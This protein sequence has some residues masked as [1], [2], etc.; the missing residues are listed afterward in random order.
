VAKAIL[1][2]SLESAREVDPRVVG[3][4]G[5]GEV[6]VDPPTV[7]DTIL[8]YSKDVL[9]VTHLFARDSAGTVYPLTPPSGGV[10]GL[11]GTC[12]VSKAGN[13]ATAVRGNLALPF[14]TVQAALT[15]ALSGDTISIGP[16]TYAENIVMPDTDNLALEGSGRMDTIIVSAA[17]GHT[18]TWAPVVNAIGRLQVANL[19]IRNTGGAGNNPVNLDGSA[20]VAFAQVLFLFANVLFDQTGG[21]GNSFAA[22]MVSNIT[23]SNC[24]FTGGVVLLQEVSVVVF[25]TC[26]IPGGADWRYQDGG[27]TPTGGRS[28]IA[29]ANGSTIGDA[30]LAL[31]GPGLTLRDNPLIVCDATSGIYSSIVGVGLAFYSAGPIHAPIVIWLG[32]IGSPFIAGAGVLTLPLPAIPAAPLAPFMYVD[33]SRATFYGTGLVTLTIGGAIA[34][35]IIAR[36]CRFE[37][38]GVGSVSIGTLLNLDA[39]DSFFASQAAFAVVGTGTLDRSRWIV[40]GTVNP[41]G[42]VVVNF[43]AF[44]NA[45]YH[46]AV[47]LVNAVALS[48][49]VTAKAA[50]GVTVLAAAAGGTIDVLISRQP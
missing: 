35:T 21:A 3:E 49:V 16:G 50:G 27:V 43:L 2:T 5:Y 42:P 36:Q 46:A 13:D 1:P 19:T 22:T 32:F 12:Y 38:T 29:L 7:A 48:S 20:V 47:T 26:G 9:G 23:L 17:A 45:T 15:A 4:I 30:N 10:V 18:L 37:K 39:R 40:L 28:V 33:F 41:G 34:F 24:S 44:P 31:G 25:D 6:A 14:L 8:T 11:A